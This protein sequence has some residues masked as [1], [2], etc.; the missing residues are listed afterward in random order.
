MKRRSVD[1]VSSQRYKDFLDTVVEQSADE[2]REIGEVTSRY[3]TLKT[4]RQDNESRLQ[5]FIEG[6]EEYK[7]QLVK[8]KHQK[9]AE[10]MELNNDA[11]KLKEKAESVRSSNIALQKQTE[12][13]SKYA[14]SRTLKLGLIK[15]ACD[16]IFERIQSSSTLGRRNKEDS[17]LR[18][19]E[20]SGDY[21]KDLIDI[22]KEKEA[23]IGEENMPS[24]WQSWSKQRRE[25][26]AHHGDGDEEEEEEEEEEEGEP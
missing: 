8:F 23:E 15:M 16:N 9:E 12:A 18:I 1:V 7:Q 21:I 19:L 22:C 17:I 5:T 2:Y 6:N 11:T 10:M 13:N 4:L 24:T 3:E 25:D 26:V 20:V 14:Q